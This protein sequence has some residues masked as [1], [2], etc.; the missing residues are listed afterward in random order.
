MAE[1]YF[2]GPVVQERYILDP[3]PG[4]MVRVAGIEGTFIYPRT[5]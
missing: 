4:G 1:K 3:E 5:Q 2:A